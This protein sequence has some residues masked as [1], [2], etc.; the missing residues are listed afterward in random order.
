MRH[1]EGL[2]EDSRRDIEDKLVWGEK[3]RRRV[4]G[5]GSDESEYSSDDQD[6]DVSGDN[7]LDVEGGLEKIKQGASM[8]Y[9]SSTRRRA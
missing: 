4:K 1:K 7:G 5:I 8:N 6:D 3:L 2:N 9:R